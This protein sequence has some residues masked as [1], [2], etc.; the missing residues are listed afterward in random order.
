MEN[1]A[2]HKY[3]IYNPQK[4]IHKNFVLCLYNIL[5]H[6]RKGKEYMTTM[7]KTANSLGLS[8]YEEFKLERPNKEFE[9]MKF[10]LTE[11]GLE[12]RTEGKHFWDLGNADLLADILTGRERIKFEN[13]V[14]EDEEIFGLKN[15][16]NLYKMNLFGFEKWQNGSWISCHEIAEKIRNKK[17]DIIRCPKWVLTDDE[18]EMI[19]DIADGR[20]ILAITKIRNSAFSFLSIDLCCEDNSLEFEELMYNKDKYFQI[21]E[22]EK[23]YTPKELGL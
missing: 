15:E 11:L 12:C 6:K 2:F 19:I 8:L 17:E 14:L 4:N 5:Q 7:E 13:S 9:K 16:T 20:R 23:M 22:F 10:R 18:K 21:L 3:I 1:Y